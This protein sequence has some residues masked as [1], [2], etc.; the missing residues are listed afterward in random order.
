[1]KRRSDD[2]NRKP[3]SKCNIQ[4][5][6]LALRRAAVAGACIGR[7]RTCTPSLLS[8]SQI[9]IVRFRH[10]PSHP[11]QRFTSYPNFKNVF[12]SGRPPLEE[13][14]EAQRK[15]KADACNDNTTCNNS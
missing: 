11:L 5:P 7:Q 8:F 10:S 4:Y 13:T 1:M 2:Y 9:F 3:N 14:L 15:N 12:I 6:I